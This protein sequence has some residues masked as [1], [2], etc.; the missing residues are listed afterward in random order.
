MFEIIIVIVILF[1]IIYYY[2]KKIIFG[3]FGFV[4]FLFFGVI[5]W[6]D[7]SWL[8]LGLYEWIIKYGDIF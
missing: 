5:F 3:F 7:F 2:C 4:G 6:I 8:Y 1:F